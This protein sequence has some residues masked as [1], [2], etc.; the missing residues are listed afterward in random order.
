MQ[1]E[2]EIYLSREEPTKEDFVFAD[3][4]LADLTLESESAKMKI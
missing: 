3:A 4:P 2:V 1:A